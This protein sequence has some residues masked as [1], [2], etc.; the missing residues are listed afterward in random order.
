MILSMKFKE[1]LK[2]A[3]LRNPGR[4]TWCGVATDGTPVF[5]IW[6]HDIRQINS[7]LFAWWDH[8]DCHYPSPTAT[9]TQIA[10]RRSFVKLAAANIDQ[11][12]RAVIVRRK[13]RSW[14]AA[15]AEYPHPEMAVARFRVANVDAA[16]FIVELFPAK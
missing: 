14:E 1:A 10:K 8:G 15:S 4:T 3:G 9:A 11:E 16:Q 6:A 12:C 7:R 13:G 2:A 5:T